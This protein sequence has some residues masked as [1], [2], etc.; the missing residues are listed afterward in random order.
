MEDFRTAHGHDITSRA[1]K[2]A[3]ILETNILQ[4]IKAGIIKK[5]Q[6]QAASGATE[7]RYKLS[8]DWRSI[9]G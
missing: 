9:N 3:G 6:V 2:D 7:N 4:A 5:V 1:L 8:K